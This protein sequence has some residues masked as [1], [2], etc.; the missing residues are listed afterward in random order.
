M[1]MR[2]VRKLLKAR[3]LLKKQSDNRPDPKWISRTRAYLKRKQNG[4]CW[5][6]GVKMDFEHRHSETFATIDHLHPLSKGGGWKRKNLS[7][8]CYSCNNRRGNSPAKH[9]APNP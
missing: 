9:Y 7:L 1:K 4:K 8:A 2:F 5:I 6:C 3:K